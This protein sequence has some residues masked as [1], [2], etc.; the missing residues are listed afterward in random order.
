[1]RSCP[2]SGRDEVQVEVG[3]RQAKAGVAKD[4][5]AKAVATREKARAEGEEVM[6]KSYMSR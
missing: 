5:A 6:A 1:M 3:R 4:V 2:L